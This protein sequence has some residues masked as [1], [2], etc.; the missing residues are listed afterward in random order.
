MDDYEIDSLF[1][2]LFG[3]DG[4]DDDVMDTI[5]KS[6]CST[7]HSP[8]SDHQ[9][10]KASVVFKKVN[11]RN[12][13][14]VFSP[15]EVGFGFDATGRKCFWFDGRF[16]LHGVTVA[17]VAS[18][19]RPYITNQGY[20][21]AE[22]VMDMFGDAYVRLAH[23]SDPTPSP[24]NARGCTAA[25]SNQFYFI[26]HERSYWVEIYNLD[27]SNI[28]SGLVTFDHNGALKHPLVYTFDGR[29]WAKVYGPM[30]SF[31]YKVNK[32]TM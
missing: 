20:V 5:F 9:V 2:A 18:C 13:H 10:N 14:S 24:N 22:G 31:L 11:V 28:S 21:I 27:V 4:M 32:T 15:A 1:E 29:V 3:E 6:E 16:W 17:E 25:K 26:M 8:V 19:A 23:E 7:I 12:G 30:K